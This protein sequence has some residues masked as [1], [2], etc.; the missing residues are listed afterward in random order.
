MGTKRTSAEF[1][2]ILYLL[3]PGKPFCSDI[4][5]RAQIPS[6]YVLLSSGWWRM[7]WINTIS[8]SSQPIRT[9]VGGCVWGVCVC[10]CCDGLFEIPVS[11]SFSSWISLVRDLSNMQLL[12]KENG[13]V[14]FWVDCPFRK[15]I[16]SF[17]KAAAFTIRHHACPLGPLD[18]VRRA[19]S[20]DVIE[21][22]P[23]VMWDFPWWLR[24]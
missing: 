18:K 8:L 3:F 14:V 10:V 23:I 4:L 24:W 9:G 2:S 15:Q 12:R 5:P 1:G 22:L 20:S 6:E 16:W 19:V 21:V 7:V 11:S 17:T 13:V